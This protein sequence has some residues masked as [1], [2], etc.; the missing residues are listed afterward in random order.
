MKDIAAAW[1]Q[2]GSQQK[3][4]WTAKSAKGSASPFVTE[5]AVPPPPPPPEG[6]SSVVGE[7]GGAWGIKNPLVPESQ[8]LGAASEV[9]APLSLLRAPGPPVH[10]ARL[11]HSSPSPS[12][13]PSSS[14]S[15]DSPPARSTAPPHRSP[16]LIHRTP[17][18]LRPSPLLSTALLCSST[19]LL[20]SSTPLFSFLCMARPIAAQTEAGRAGAPKN[21]R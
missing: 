17:L 13:S 1:G 16:L 7:G 5:I 14:P 4:E 15:P 8:L 6:S 20:V 19:P 21:A 12:P 18:L 2:L 9:L 3:D 10:F 11:I